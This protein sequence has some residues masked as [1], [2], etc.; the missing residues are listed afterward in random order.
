[1]MTGTDI[2]SLIRFMQSALESPE[3]ID[4]ELFRD[5]V[6]AYN[7]LVHE[8]NAHLAASDRLLDAGRRDE[9]IEYSER[10]GNLLEMYEKLDIPEIE[11]W[12]E[13]VTAF[14]LPAPPRLHEDAAVQLNDAY[15]KL[16]ELRPLLTRHRLLALDHAPLRY[17][18]ITLA[19]LAAQDPLNPVW[20][21]GVE[22]FQKARLSEIPRDLDRAKPKHSTKA[23]WNRPKPDRHLRSVPIRL[24]QPCRQSGHAK[25]RLQTSLRNSRPMIPSIRTKIYSS[26]SAS[27]P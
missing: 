27:W 20:Q 3:R 11:L 4:E 8:L 21:D 22:E 9:A 14:E 10:N 17:R 26:S 2:D 16:N 19:E 12:C 5:E 24:P 7:D 1:M 15:V 6:V 13:L 23:N 25:K 18:L